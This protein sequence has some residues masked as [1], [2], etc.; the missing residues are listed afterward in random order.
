[1]PLWMADKRSRLATGVVKSPQGPRN[2]TNSPVRAVPSGPLR[3][4]GAGL[5]LKQS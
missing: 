1:M 2:D 3:A 4:L 5:K